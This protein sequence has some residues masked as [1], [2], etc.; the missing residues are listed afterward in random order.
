MNL[1]TLLINHKLEGDYLKKKK[2]I[3]TLSIIV[4]LMLTGIITNNKLYKSYKTEINYATFQMERLCKIFGFEMKIDSDKKSS[5]TDFLL[6][7]ITFQKK[8]YDVLIPQMSLLET[9]KSK[10]R[11]ANF[12]NNLFNNPRFEEEKMYVDDLDLIDEKGLTTEDIT[13]NP[14]ET[15]N[16]IS[17]L[18]IQFRMWHH[19]ITDLTNNAYP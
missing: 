15:Y 13:K 5:Y 1:Q 18:Q 6:K 10:M 9:E 19:D 17:E 14:Q 12:N 2:L 3:I 8:D 7:T 11:I 4:V 16:I